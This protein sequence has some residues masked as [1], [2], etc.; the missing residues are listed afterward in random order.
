MVAGET[1]HLTLNAQTHVAEVLRHVNGN[2]T[3]QVRHTVGFHAQETKMKL[4]RVTLTYVQV[5]TC[6]NLFYIT[7]TLIL[8]VSSVVLLFPLLPFV[9]YDGLV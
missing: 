4:S 2:A 8:H 1:G 6:S 7:L 9:G 5:V 3:I